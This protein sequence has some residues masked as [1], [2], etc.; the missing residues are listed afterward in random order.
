MNVVVAAAAVVALVVSGVIF[1]S[2]AF[3]IET[4][5]YFKWHNCKCS[6]IIFIRWN[7]SEPIIIITKRATWTL[8][9]ND[10]AKE[11]PH[12]RIIMLNEIR[13]ILHSN[14]LL[15][16]AE[17]KAFWCN[18]ITSLHILQ[19]THIN[20]ITINQKCMS[21]F[22]C[23]HICAGSKAKRKCYNFYF[24]HFTFCHFKFTEIPIAS[25]FSWFLFDHNFLSGAVVFLMYN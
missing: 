23:N 19:S 13:W 8:K 16:F 20:I 12:F 3:T 1:G 10:Q 25:F 22:F 5:A 21:L 24:E 6:S 18:L 17:P 7:L 9:H 11:R 15:R 14:A 4:T 2:K